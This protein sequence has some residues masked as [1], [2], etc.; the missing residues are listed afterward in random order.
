MS[1]GFLSART[2]G[3]SL[4]ANGRYATFVGTDGSDTNFFVY[5]RVEKRTIQVDL[6]TNGGTAGDGTAQVNGEEPTISADGRFV[7]FSSTAADLVPDDA[8]GV[9]DAFLRGPL[10]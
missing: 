10:H 1:F 3:D 6:D 2:A 4:S 8:N 5:D 9:E 7:A